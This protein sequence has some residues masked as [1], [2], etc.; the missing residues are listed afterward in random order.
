MP[1]ARYD[2]PQSGYFDHIDGHPP[3][4]FFTA[5]ANAP[6]VAEEPSEDPTE[7]TPAEPVPTC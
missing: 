7:E 5:T 6:A 1:N 2:R 3:R 4:D